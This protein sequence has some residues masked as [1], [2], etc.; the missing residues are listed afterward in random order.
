MI[1]FFTIYVAGVLLAALIIILHNRLMGSNHYYK[2]PPLFSLLSFAAFILFLI[3][4]IFCFADGVYKN[5]FKDVYN[6]IC[7]NFFFYDN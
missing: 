7:K 5:P 1:N 6:K 3:N 2:M 4:A